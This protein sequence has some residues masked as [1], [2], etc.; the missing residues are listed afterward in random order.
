MIR[1]WAFCAVLAA[2]AVSAPVDNDFP[3]PP[4]PEASRIPDAPQ[5]QEPAVSAPPLGEEGKPDQTSLDGL[6]Q[7]GPGESVGDKEEPEDLP[8]QPEAAATEGNDFILEIQA[9]KEGNAPKHSLETEVRAAESSG[10]SSS[11]DGRPDAE[12]TAQAGSADALP[13]NAGEPA[14]EPPVPVEFSEEQPGQPATEISAQ[15][16]SSGDPSEGT[17]QTPAEPLPQGSFEEPLQDAEH[18]VPESSATVQPSGES[19]GNTELP[20]AAP[21]AQEESP[22]QPPEGVGRPEAGPGGELSEEIP[23]AAE[24]PAQAGSPEEPAGGAE[25]PAGEPP[26]QEEPSVEPSDGAGQPPAEPRAQEESSEQPSRDTEQ[27]TPAPT[28]GIEPSGQTTEDNG[29]AA[30]GSSTE[31]ETNGEPSEDVEQRGAGSSGREGFPTEPQPEGEALPDARSIPGGQVEPAVGQGIGVVAAGQLPQGPVAVGPAAGGLPGSRPSG[32]AV[33]GGAAP[34]VP[35]DGVPIPNVPAGGQPAV[36]IGP[37]TG[38][39]PAVPGVGVAVVQEGQ[40]QGAEQHHFQSSEQGAAQGSGAF[41]SG[42]ATK[43]IRGFSHQEGFS[44]SQGF[45]E[46]SKNKWGHGQYEGSAGHHQESSG[47]EN[48][49]AEEGYGYGV[50]GNPNSLDALNYGFVP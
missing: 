4:I 42:S 8:I 34:T 13:E 36:P 10:V 9:P 49:F 17:G 40:S 15:P 50:H 29:G 48:E 2:V 45:E 5:L 38:P 22:A 1:I 7:Q 30:D 14:A 43:D 44:N 26:A 28:T 39:V 20:T 35:E 19:S 24:S 33:P 16:E 47:H 31:P 11:D 6:P 46:E 37:A 23:A 41:E 21:P 25:P 12:P 3:I 27:P 18:Q 32:A